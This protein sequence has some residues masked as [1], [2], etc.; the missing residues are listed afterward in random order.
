M[1]YQEVITQT[2]RYENEAKAGWW[3][4]FIG[5]GKTIDTKN[6]L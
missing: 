6:I 3:D 2:G 5:D 4:K 1:Y